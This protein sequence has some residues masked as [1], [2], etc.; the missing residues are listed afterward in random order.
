MIMDIARHAS[1]LLVREKSQEHVG[2]TSIRFVIGD[3]KK[4]STYNDQAERNEA[5]TIIEHP[6]RD[7]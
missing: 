1:S 4:D 2:V 3:N 6:A 7:G 5:Q